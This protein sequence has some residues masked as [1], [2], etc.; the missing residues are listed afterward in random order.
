MKTDFRKLQVHW[1]DLKEYLQRSK[2]PV[3]HAELKGLL[4]GCF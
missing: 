4:D 1:S 3:L 2:L